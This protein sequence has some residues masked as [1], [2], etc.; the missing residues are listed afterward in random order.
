MLT[1]RASLAPEAPI[2]ALADELPPKSTTIGALFVGWGI[3]MLVFGILCLQTWLYFSRYVHDSPWLKLFVA[4]LWVLEVGH[5]ISIAHFSW[6]YLVTDYGSLPGALSERTVWSLAAVV[7]LGV[8]VAAIVKIFLGW[9]IYRVSGRHY[10]LGA[11]IVFSI[12]QFALGIA[13]AA[14]SV[15]LALDELTTLTTLPTIALSLGSATDVVIALVL[16]FY[17]HT[18]RTGYQKSERLIDRLIIFSVNTGA[19]TAAVS[20]SVVVLFQTM[21]ENFVYI[22]VYFLVCKLYSNSC[23]A[24]L[25]SRRGK[26]RG[27]EEDA[28]S[29][30][31]SH[32]LAFF[33]PRS[34]NV[35]ID[36]DTTK[37]AQSVIQIGVHQET[38]VAQ[39]GD[40]A[41]TRP[42]SD[43]GRQSSD[44]K[45]DRPGAL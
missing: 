45:Y 11:T 22:S 36:V 32:A 29:H 31:A 44:K 33:S 35:P 38:S 25:N 26:G 15:S 4:S 21:P 40:S 13:F 9:R 8:T 30:V 43:Y 16:S 7:I 1:I 19:L 24:T 42:V 28:E 12:A 41:S 3:S 34:N 27:R 39:D 14:R 18:M 6:H 2:S 5:Q 20:V 23:L 17:L 37:L 10:W